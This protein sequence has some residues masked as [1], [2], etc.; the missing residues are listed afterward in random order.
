MTWA[1]EDRV[2]VKLVLY[3]F[4]IGS[5]KGPLGVQLL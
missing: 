5:E 2:K 1:V 3:I 4:D